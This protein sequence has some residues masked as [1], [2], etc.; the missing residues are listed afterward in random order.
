M[1]KNEIYVTTDAQDNELW[2]DSVTVN[3]LH[4]LNETPDTGKTYQVRARYRAPL[5]EAIISEINEGLMTLKLQQ[6]VRA[7]A[8]G[9]SVV[10]YDGDRVIGGGIIT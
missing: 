10:I 6:P 2:R 4:W 9:Q 5:V 3:Q 8:P 1:V 7:I